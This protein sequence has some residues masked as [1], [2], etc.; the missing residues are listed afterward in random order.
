MI[1]YSD[2]ALNGVPS[3]GTAAWPKD[4]LAVLSCGT[5]SNRSSATQVNRG[6]GWVRILRNG[7]EIESFSKWDLKMTKTVRLPSPGSAL[8]WI[9]LELA[10]ANGGR[11]L[12]PSIWV[13]GN[14][15]PGAVTLPILLEDGT[16][17]DV[18][19]EAA[20]VPFFFYPCG[21]NNGAFLLDRSGYEHHGYVGGKGYGGGHLARTGYRHEHTGPVRPGGEK[22]RPAWGQDETARGFLRFDGDSYAMI[23]G[24]TAFPYAATY[25]CMARPAR[26]GGEQGILGAANGQVA[27]VILDDG[28]VRASR[29]GAV[30]GTGGSKPPRRET[31]SVTS[32]TALATGK[33]SHLAVV[34]DLRELKLYVNRDHQGSKPVAPMRSHEW[35]NAVVIGGLCRFPYK[36]VPG[37][38]GDLWN[39]R[40]YGRNL[41]LGEFVSVPQ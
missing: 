37:F 36:P 4:G 28:R 10:N 20:R 1:F 22:S 29:S 12:S 25:E 35:I 34:Y 32:T 17:V 7:R 15:R 40:I 3:G 9:N 38:V 31:V 11:Y 19:V 26:L 14:S 33:W 16:I 27:L 21:Q 39:L 24:G 5:F 30:E 2:W 23:Q 6:G 18:S 8:D 41:A 13:T